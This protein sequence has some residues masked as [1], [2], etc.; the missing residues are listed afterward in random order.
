MIAA[1]RPIA[2]ADRVEP[3]AVDAELLLLFCRIGRVLSI[4]FAV[5]GADFNA[6]GCSAAQPCRH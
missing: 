2:P 5:D 6:G 3:N 1:V 4:F